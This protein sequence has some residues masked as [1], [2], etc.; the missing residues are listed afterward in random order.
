[1]H[2]NGNGVVQCYQQAQ[3]HFNAILDTPKA[4]TINAQAWHD[5]QDFLEK[6]KS[7]NKPL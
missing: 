5:A 2:Y 1:M 4:Q 7:N 6:I 3:Q